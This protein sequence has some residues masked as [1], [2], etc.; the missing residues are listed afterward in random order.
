MSTKSGQKR[1][2]FELDDLKSNV[3]VE[4]QGRKKSRTDCK[5]SYRTLTQMDNKTISN[6]G[7]SA[8]APKNQTVMGIL[9]SKTAFNEK[10]IAIRR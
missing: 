1:F 7:V 10:K 2:T 3:I 6:G 8:G 4:D 5:P 9:A